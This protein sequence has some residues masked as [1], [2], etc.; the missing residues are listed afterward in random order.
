MALTLQARVEIKLA[1]DGAV[2]LAFGSKVARLRTELSDGVFSF[3]P[4]AGILF[5]DSAGRVTVVATP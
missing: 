3:D 4:E 2:D 1:V 5:T